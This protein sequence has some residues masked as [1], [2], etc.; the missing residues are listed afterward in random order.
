MTMAM[1]TVPIVIDDNADDNGDGSRC[2]PITLSRVSVTKKMT[3]GT[4]PAVT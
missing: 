1:E 4:V 2:K 3:V